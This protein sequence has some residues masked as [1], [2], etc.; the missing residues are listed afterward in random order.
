MHTALDEAVL[1]QIAA[2]TGG[3]YHGVG[4]QADLE[5]VYDEVETRLVV[6]S[7]PIEV[8]SLFVGAGVLVLLAG[9]A[10]S[11]AWLGRLP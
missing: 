4:S 1:Q 11:L 2:M 6:R 5:S 10:S 3:T 7:E 8:T 9:A